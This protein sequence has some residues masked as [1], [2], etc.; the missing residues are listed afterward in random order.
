MDRSI[1]DDGAVRASSSEEGVPMRGAV[2]LGAYLASAPEVDRCVAEHLHRYVHGREAGERDRGHIEEA[3]RALDASGG[4]F[5]EL[6][7]AFLT[8]EAF[9]RVTTPEPIGEVELGSIIWDE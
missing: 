7:V 3:A 6:V 2:E 9:T 8:S 1:P 5:L 4:R